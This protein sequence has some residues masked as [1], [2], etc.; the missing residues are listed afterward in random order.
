MLRIWIFLNK[1]TIYLEETTA[2]RKNQIA[3]RADANLECSHSW[4]Y[5]HPQQST[6]PWEVFSA[7]LFAIF[8]EIYWG[9]CTWFNLS[10][11][12][13]PL[14]WFR[15]FELDYCYL[16]T[17]RFS[18][19]ISGR[20]ISGV[21]KLARLVTA[22]WNTGEFQD[23]AKCRREMWTHYYTKMVCSSF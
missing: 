9:N 2:Q 3:E 7:D 18:R 1:Q 11:L 10:R 5:R 16:M 6:Y 8:K 19:K 17:Y 21:W 4:K 14:I 15:E 20:E 12:T 23:G 22:D 13:V